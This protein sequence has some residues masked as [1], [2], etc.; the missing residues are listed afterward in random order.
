VMAHHKIGDAD[1]DNSGAKKSRGGQ[2]GT[3][4]FPEG[5]MGAVSNALRDAAIANGAVVRTKAP[6]ARIDTRNGRVRGVTLESGEALRADVVIAATHPKI[7][8]LDQIDRG[9][10]PTDFVEAIERW[11]TRSG[12]VKVNV[13]VDRLPEFTAKPGFDPEV[14]GG[15]IVLAESLDDVEHAFQDAVGGR[16]AGLPFADICIP[17]VFDPT[18]AP[19]GQHVVSM[20]TQWVPHQWASAKNTDELESYADRVV[21]RVNAVAPGFTDSVLRRQVIGPYE[22]EHEYGLIGR[23]IFH[24]ELSPDQLFHMRP[25]PGYAD[26]RTP[27]AGLYQASS[28]THGGGG[29]TGIPGLN[30]TRQIMRDRARKRWRRA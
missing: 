2:S 1:A 4:G 14:H 7:T 19:V 26:F 18:L 15:T 23:N 11:K 16:A 20:F 5:G 8:F 13:A 24:G 6:V 28:A 17:S 22:M 10:L 21:A 29:V 12:T 3:W 25:A 9:A 30:A 27:I